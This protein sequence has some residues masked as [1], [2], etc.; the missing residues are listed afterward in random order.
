M[1]H[2]SKAST[3]NV[4]VT[5]VARYVPERSNPAMSN[6]FFAYQVTIANEGA[7]PVRL[8][9]RHWIITDALN[10]VEEVEGVGVIGETPIIQPGEDY[11]YTSFCPLKTVFGTMRGTYGMVRPNGETFHATIASFSLLGP[12]AVQ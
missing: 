6:Y 8:L 5:V 9:T 2:A 4:R 1:P 3:E 10:R 11:T 12:N 7:M